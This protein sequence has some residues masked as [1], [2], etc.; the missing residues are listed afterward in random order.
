MTTESNS[1]LQKCIRIIGIDPGYARCGWSILDKYNDHQ[2]LVAYGCIETTVADPLEQRMLVIYE[3]IAAILKKYHPSVAGIETIYFSISTKTAMK[4]SEAR[5]VI[6]LALTQNNVAVTA[7]TPGQI[8]RA[9]TGNWKGSKDE[10]KAGVYATLSLTENIK[11]DDT[12]DAI[13]AALTH[14]I[15]VSNP[16]AHHLAVCS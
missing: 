12:V 1:E 8:K 3:G 2:Y 10:V 11:P 5:G 6:I 14:S 4:V 15:T 9:V 13:A 7:Y 16:E